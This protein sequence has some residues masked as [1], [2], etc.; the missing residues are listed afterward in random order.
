[1]SYIAYDINAMNEV[2]AI[3]SAC[4]TTPAVI[5]WGLPQMWLHCFRGKQTVVTDAHLAAF[6]ARAPHIGETLET[7]G[8]LERV[9]GGWRVRGAERRLKIREAQSEGGR[10]GR[11]KSSSPIGRKVDPVTPARS[12]S[13]PPSSG[14]SGRKVDP[15]PATRSTSKSTSNGDNVDP[16]ETKVSEVVSE[17]SSD[18]V[19]NDR[20]DYKVYPATSQ[21]GSQGPHRV[22]HQITNTSSPSGK[23]DINARRDLSAEGPGKPA[24]GGQAAGPDDAPVEA[25]EQPPPDLPAALSPL[26]PPDPGESLEAFLERYPWPRDLGDGIHPHAMQALSKHG[27][28]T[29]QKPRELRELF[30]HRLH[31]DAMVREEAWT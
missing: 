20:V 17:V 12:T 30:T 26:R 6:F 13:K 21:G 22:L 15:A 24:L 19:S 2:P 10:K 5:G 4:N 23:R 18:V 7:F 16:I 9:E 3:A 1:M 27:L 29:K 11:A 25:N 28:A 14:G 31:G 8:F